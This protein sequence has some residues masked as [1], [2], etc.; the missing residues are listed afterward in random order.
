MSVSAFSAFGQ[1]ICPRS[2]APRLTLSG[3]YYGPSQARLPKTRGL[4]TY[5]HT[6]SW[7]IHNSSSEVAALFAAATRHLPRPSKET[8]IQVQTGN[9]KR[10]MKGTPHTDKGRMF[11]ANA[12]V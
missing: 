8:I 2:I 7:P 1:R 10:C 11:R 5:N 9:E 3:L 12:Q 6:A 4:A